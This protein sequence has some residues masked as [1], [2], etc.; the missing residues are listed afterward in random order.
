MK[1]NLTCD[2]SHY[3]MQAVIASLSAKYKTTHTVVFGCSYIG[4]GA[5]WFRAKYPHLA[6]GAIASSAP[7][8]AVADFYKYLDQ[9]DLSI[10]EQFGESCDDALRTA[11]HGINSM[12]LKDDPNITSLFNL[13]APLESVDDKRNFVSSV[14]GDIMGVVQYDFEGSGTN[15]IPY[16]CG[17]LT[18]NGVDPLTALAQYFTSGEGCNDVSYQSMIDSLK[19][20]DNGNVSSSRQWTY[21]TCSEFG[22]FQTTTSPTQPFAEGDWV[23]L[24]WYN[25]MCTDIFGRPFDI[26]ANIAETNVR[27]GGN[28]LPSY[29]ATNVVYDNSIV[30]PWHT[31]S[32]QQSVNPLSPLLLYNV[33]GHCAAVSR[34]EDDDPDEIKEVRKQISSIIGGWLSS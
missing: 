14:M 5:A 6:V 31:L 9:V 26:D 13:C 1:S 27:F 2:F 23:T 24:D 29:Y 30:D 4:S 17:I 12:L 25:Q 18:K 34:P 19:I 7:V 32:V 11:M 33:R 8:L 21:Q 16:V 28:Q 10:K 15:N 22:Y 20:V 3:P